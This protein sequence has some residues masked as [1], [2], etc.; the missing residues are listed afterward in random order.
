MHFIISIFSLV[1][2]A[3]IAWAFSTA[4]HHDPGRPRGI[5]QAF[6]QIDP[7]MHRLGQ[8]LKHGKSKLIACNVGEGTHAEAMSFLTDVAMATKNLLVTCGAGASDT[9]HIDICA[10]DEEPIGICPD[11]VSAAEVG[12]ARAVYLLSKGGTR[13]GVGSAAIA[14]KGLWLYTAAGGKVQVEPTVAGT[15]WRVGRNLSTCDGDGK[16]VE[17]ET[18]PPI[19]LVVVAAFTS[20][21][22][23]A[24][25]ASGS[26]ANLAA[27]AEKIG[28]DVRSLGAALVT[29]ALVKVLT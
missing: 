2:F 20:T 1:A 29:P 3:A 27:E 24:A 9:N 4:S 7:L 22:G 17:I 13:L 25:A 8:F 21:N 5:V 12:E 11:E 16:K 15:Y 14:T 10:A 19:K 26:L 28:D 6:R 18:M 23:T